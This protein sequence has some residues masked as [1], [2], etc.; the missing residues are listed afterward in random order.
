MIEVIIERWINVDQSVDHLW[1]VWHD[2][3]RIEMGGTHATAESAED[4]ALAYCRQ[5]LGAEPDR[6]T[7]L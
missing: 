2:G 5:A 7:R 3:E 6:V 1:S 4:E